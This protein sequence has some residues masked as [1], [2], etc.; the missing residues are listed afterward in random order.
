M[1]DFWQRLPD[2]DSHFAALIDEARS[3]GRVLTYLARWDGSQARV[4]LEALDADHPCAGVEGCDNLFSFETRCY[5]DSPLVIRGPGAGAAVT[6]AGVYG[7]LR[8]ALE[9]AAQ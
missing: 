3:K 9:G 2:V 8:R 4:G 5:T 7:D 1:D 6:A